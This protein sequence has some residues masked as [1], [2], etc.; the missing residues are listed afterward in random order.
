MVQRHRNIHMYLA[1]A[2]A[3]AVTAALVF[4]PEEA[5]T[6]SLEGL[7][8]WLEVVLPALLP[9]FIMAE[10]LMSLGVVHFIGTLLEPIM[11]PLFKIP[12]VGAFALAIGLASGYPIGA[13]ITGKLRRENLCSQ[14]EAERLISFANTADPLF[15]A[16]AVAIGLFGMPEI[17][18]TLLLAHYCSVII[19]GF[20]MRFYGHDSSTIL[21]AKKQTNKSIFVN[22]V[23]ALVKARN[24]DHRPF[25]TMIHDAVIDSFKSLSFVGGCIVSFAVLSKLFV[26]AGITPVL[27]DCLS[28]LLSFANIGQDIINGVLTGIFEID[29]GAQLVSQSQSPIIHK[30]VAASAIIGW[31]GLS[32]H[33]Q[34][35]AMIHGT[36][37]RIKPYILARF[38]HA[39]VAGIMA[40][41]LYKPATTMWY[42]LHQTVPVFDAG[43]Y[44][45]PSFL[46][47]LNCSITTAGII[48][49]GLLLLGLIIYL[50]SRIIV[51]KI[52]AK[53]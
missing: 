48:T 47:I 6:S 53:Q 39:I 51:I 45:R 35:A 13:K 19:V 37:I 22:A 10:L 12:G 50:F 21:H 32:V 4:F 20:T 27:S 25:G 42:K 41:L 29:I 26:I 11:Q 8:L 34:A 24:N 38:L 30:L 15:M 43:L 16:G 28:A 17:A 40:A 1:A 46:T 7:R 49:I 44:T 5:F 18:V 3:L 9:F 2:M 52:S 14:V 36:D 23:N 31:S 33:V